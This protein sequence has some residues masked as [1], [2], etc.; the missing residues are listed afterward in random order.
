[1]KFT[2]TLPQ[3]ENFIHSYS[4]HVFFVFTSVVAWK[5]NKKKAW[6]YFINNLLF[7]QR[8]FSFH[9]HPKPQTKQMAI[10]FLL[11][12]FCFK[13]LLYTI[14]LFIYTYLPLHFWCLSVV[15]RTIF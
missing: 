11:C 14:H 5:K 2:P 12:K 4:K 13:S 9:S 6:F 3:Q 1:M 8:E 15:Y 10:C 7:T